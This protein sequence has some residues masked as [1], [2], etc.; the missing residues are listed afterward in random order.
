MMAP[1]SDLSYSQQDYRFD[2]ATLAILGVKPEKPPLFEFNL[3]GVGT[4]HFSFEFP[5]LF[6]PISTSLLTAILG[7]KI[8]RRLRKFGP[9]RCRKCG[10]SA[11]GNISGVCPE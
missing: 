4:D 1:P 2:I 9:G 8:S 3:G 7:W 5:L 6:F 10:Y 11:T